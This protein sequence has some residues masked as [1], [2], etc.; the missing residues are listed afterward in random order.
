MAT[1]SRKHC[2]AG[3]ECQPRTFEEGA[4]CLGHHSTN[5]L[6]AMAKTMQRDYNYLAKAFSPF[7]DTH[8]LRGDLLVPATLASGD[9]PAE[10]NYTL[11]DWM[12]QAVGRVAFVLPQVG[13]GGGDATGVRL[14]QQ[15]IQDFGQLLATS[16]EAL[17]DGRLTPE[18]YADLKS[19][20]AAVIRA[21]CVFSSF[22]DSIAPTAA[23]LR[24]VPKTGTGS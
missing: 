21:L 17:A 5:R 20:H 4:D 15:A 18:E 19:K 14:T 24:V 7:A 23:A 11:L 3:D 8:P 16:G 1:T 9:T 10:R 2:Q 22:I 13:V 6:P 12:E